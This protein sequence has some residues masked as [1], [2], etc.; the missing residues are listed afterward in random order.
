MRRLPYLLPLLVLCVFGAVTCATYKSD[1]ER[2][3]GHYQDNQ[4]GQARKNY[5]ENQYE[6]ALALLRVLEHDIDSFTPGEQAQYSY[7]RGMTDYRLS[8]SPRLSQQ[9]QGSAV[10]DPRKDYRSNAR[11]WLGVAAAIEKVTPGGLTPDEKQRMSDVLTD[12][13]KDVYG[14]AESLPEGDADAGADA[15]AAAAP[16]ATPSAPAAPAS[17]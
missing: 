8:Q 4:V 14:G 12:L 7:L 15:A 16:E 13:N 5:E 3:R 17:K 1:L 6:K 2:A 10:A 9:T 11:H